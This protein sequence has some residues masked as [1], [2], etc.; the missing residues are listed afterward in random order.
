MQQEQNEK[1]KIK[2]V[3]SLFKKI[4]KNKRNRNSFILAIVLILASLF[5]YY[6]ISKDE[7]FYKKTIAKVTDITET[8]DSEAYDMSGKAEQ[9]YMQHIKAVIMN[10]SHKG[11]NVQLQ[12][13]RSFSQAYDLSLKVK[14]EVF[15]WVTEDT[16]KKITSVSIL[17]LKRDKYIA[18]IV[19]LF[20][21]LIL[22]IG[23]VKGIRSLS[24]V[25]VNIIIFSIVIEL[26]LHG[27]NLIFVGSIA[28]ILFIIIS[29]SLVSGI[30]KKT[31]AAIIGT[32]VGTIISMLIAIV[33]IY[34]TK[35]KGLHYEEMEF[36]TRPPVQIFILEILIGTLGGIMDIAISISS[37]I[38]EI[39][40]K[41][42]MIER[43]VLIKSGMEIGKDIMGTMANTLVFAYISGS[44][45]MILLWMKNGYSTYDLITFNIN[46]EIIRALTG[47][48]GIVV[49]IP[50][51]LYISVLFI[52]KSKIGAA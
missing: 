44:I 46:L 48:I 43:R 28:S 27:W 10:G 38:M 42:P 50:F 19:I 11:E 35:G 14:D 29:I 34:V 37:A 21:L 18:F 6:F 15:I 45:P 49:S 36:I 17:D 52:R 20:V 2:Y 9:I 32:M 40:D 26:Y 16:D 41:N 51:T 30:N 23:G 47:S 13:K 25:I 12:N 4:T 39:Y 33:V 8:K 24:S 22:L 7:A 1:A 31:S 3:I 5:S